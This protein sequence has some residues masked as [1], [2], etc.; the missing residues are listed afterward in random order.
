MR[1]EADGYRPRALTNIWDRLHSATSRGV[2]PKRHLTGWLVK[3]R[4]R[5]HG[6]NNPLSL[7]PE[8]E[9]DAKPFPARE[10]KF[11]CVYNLST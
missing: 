10:Q 1:G 2:F 3:T 9:N 11:G 6:K 5:E 7:D 8:G 4:L